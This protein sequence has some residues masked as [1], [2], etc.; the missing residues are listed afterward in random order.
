MPGW[1]ERNHGKRSLV[2][3]KANVTNRKTIHI[4]WGDCDPA[5]I[6][7]YPRYLAY[8]DA[9]T[10]ALFE[11]AGLPIPE[12][13]VQHKIVGI[14]MVDLRVSFMAPSRVSDVV[15]VESEIIKWGRSS[16]CV[17]H[18]L[19]NG[20]KLAVEC[21][22]TRVWATA[23]VTDPE[24]IESKPIPPKVIGAFSAKSSPDR[25]RKNSRRTAR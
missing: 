8:F 20:S 17:R 7:H 6:V 3:K 22:E 4:E 11:K 13:F 2:S 19:F 23:S 18:K 9:C 12:M 24:E 21:V 10:S 5:R 15:V 16:F 14:P 1:V 25:V